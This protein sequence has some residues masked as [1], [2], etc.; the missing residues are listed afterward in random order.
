MNKKAGAAIL[1]AMLLVSCGRGAGP[2]PGSGD[3]SAHEKRTVRFPDAVSCRV[4]M[5]EGCSGDVRYAAA[6]IAAALECAGGDGAVFTDSEPEREKEIL[7]GN[8][9]RAG[10]AVRRSEIR[11]GRQDRWYHIG[12]SG[13]KIFIL[14]SDDDALFCGARYFVSRILSGAVK[15]Q[16]VMIPENSTFECGAREACAVSITEKGAERTFAA[17][18]NLGEAPWYA[19]CTGRQDVTSVLKKALA[20]VRSKGG[21]IV[22]L[23]AGVYR[24]TEPLTVDTAVTLRG[25]YAN[26]D[27]RSLSEGTTLLFSLK[28]AKKLQD[29]VTLCQNAALQG[30]TVMYDDQDG[31]TRYGFSVKGSGNAFTV[32]DCNLINS[33]DGI[34]SGRTPVGMVTVENVKGTVLHTGLE[35]E[36]HADICVTT[37]LVLSPSYWAA[38]GGPDGGRI[39]EIMFSNGSVGMYMGDVDRDTFENI[40]LDGFDTGIYNRAPTR[41]GFSA[42]FYNLNI[43]KCRTGIEARGLSAAY[44]ICIAGGRIEASQKAVVNLSSGAQSA[45]NAVN[46]ALEGEIEGRINAINGEKLPGRSPAALKDV[47]SAPAKL[48][49]ITSYG[50]DRNGRKDVSEALQQALNDAE[51][52][53]GGIV[54]IPAG[55]YLLEEPVTGGANICVQGACPNAQG[56]AADFSGSVIL[57]THGQGLDGGGQAAVTLNGGGSGVTGITVYYPE[58]GIYNDMTGRKVRSYSPF[59]RCLGDSSYFTY[60]CLVACSRAVCFEGADGF[61]ADRLTGTF[62][63][64]GVSAKNCRGGL[65]SRIHTNG[66]Y[67]SGE[68]KDKTVLGEDWFSDTDRLYEAVIDGVLSGRLVQV[69]AED[70]TGLT[71]SHTFYYGGLNLI[72]AEKSDITAVCCEGART[73]A[74]TFVLKGGCSLYVVIC[75]R[76]NG[77]AYI[78]KTG[79]GNDAHMIMFNNSLTVYSGQA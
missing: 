32:R 5:P 33:W 41:A 18:V 48:Y 21:G 65:I 54:Y 24:V 58:N 59:L 3:T 13:D 42:S 27:A 8:V 68:K 61:V 20:Y 37:D 75:N 10:T 51:K 60:S 9:R 52:N 56:A 36:Q 34:S 78:R 44:G 43:L 35:A 74:E 79:G 40:T 63:D 70:C 26:P 17:E 50:A 29:S 38:N 66:T 67:L 31:T 39:R 11:N 28:G 2:G 46:V 71:V 12:V 57:V 69:S 62:Y 19:D 25:V 16:D 53:G 76:P 77:S 30:I 45:V 72:S 73:T 14:G 7:V 6:G 55:L 15:G 47:P 64:C 22:F 23:P 4:I 1:A 49:D